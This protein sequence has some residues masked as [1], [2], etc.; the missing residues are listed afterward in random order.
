[1]GLDIQPRA[2]AWATQAITSRHPHF[3]FVAADVRSEHYNPH[4]GVSAEH[5][6]L[7][8]D[9][10]SFDVV[11]AASLFT[12]LLPGAAANYLRECG[13]VLR[14]GGRAL[15]SLFLSERH[16]RGGHNAFHYHFTHAVPGQP[17]I[18]VHDPRDPEA[19]VSYSRDHIFAAV[20][21]AGLKVERVIP[22]HWPDIPEPTLN[23]QDLL[24]LSR[25]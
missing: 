21:D 17:G 18:A 25:E 2:I 13:R 22:G 4:G 6:R 15:I 9:D 20:A 8:F 11:F 7:P 24:V 10:A 1:M 19:I 16:G 12:H 23:E 14:A 3:T 5:Y